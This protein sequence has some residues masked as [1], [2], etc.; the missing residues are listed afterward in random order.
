MTDQPTTPLTD[1]LRNDQLTAEM[2]ATIRPIAAAYLMLRNAG[3]PEDAAASIAG[4]YGDL[5][6]ARHFDIPTVTF[7]SIYTGEDD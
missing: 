4:Q 3:M 6:L 5:R 7:R 2:N 1:I